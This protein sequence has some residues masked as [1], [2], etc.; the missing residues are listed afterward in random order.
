M[1]INMLVLDE[2]HHFVMDETSEVVIDLCEKLPRLLLLTA[3]PVLGDIKVLHKLI[4]L[5][6]S[7]NYKNITLKELK[8]RVEK[9]I[10]LEN[11]LEV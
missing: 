9:V 2:A 11:F 5:L 4:K 6:D 3:T 10:L 8:E 1:I 7:D